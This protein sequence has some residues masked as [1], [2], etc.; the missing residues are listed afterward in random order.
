MLAFKCPYCKKDAFL[1]DQYNFIKDLVIVEDT[2]GHEYEKPLHRYFC[3]EC[4]VEMN[5]KITK[6]GGTK[7]ERDI[8]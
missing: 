5:V 1:E 7:F 6:K 2:F 8:D 3:S 4:H